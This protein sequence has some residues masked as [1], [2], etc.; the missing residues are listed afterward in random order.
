M[1]AEPYV[2]HIPTMT[3][4]VGYRELRHFYA[5]DF[6]ES[7][8]PD[9]TLIP[10]S[11]T[12]GATQIVDELL[13]CFTHTREIPWM[14]PGIAPTGRRVEIPLVA[15]VKFRGN[16]LYH[17]HIY[18]DQASVLVQI[19]VLDAAGLPVAGIETARKLLDETQ[20]SNTL[21]KNWTRPR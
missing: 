9:T 6:V 16:K 19:G 8:P 4:G 12:M 5:N 14:L 3:G 1:V 17:E 15:I 20:P 11:R 18:W 21:M 2:N 7:N 13:F 10:I